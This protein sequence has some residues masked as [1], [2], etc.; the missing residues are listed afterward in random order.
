MGDLSRAVEV[1]FGHPLE[2][3]KLDW[4]KTYRDLSSVMSRVKE[5]V[6]KAAKAESLKTSGL[7]TEV[8]SATIRKTYSLQQMLQ[9]CKLCTGRVHTHTH[10]HTQSSQTLIS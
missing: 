5:M 4:K 7:N 10:T 1:A 9:I 3:H 2:E 6:L 8:N